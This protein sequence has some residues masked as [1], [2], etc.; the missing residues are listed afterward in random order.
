MEAPRLTHLVMRRP[1]LFQ[2][3]NITSLPEG[4]VLR[5]FN[6]E[7]DLKSLA[8]TLSAAFGFLWDAERVRS[9]L[10]EAPDVKAVYLVTW[11]GRPVATASSRY[12]PDLFPKAGYVHWV[13]T[14]P[15]HAR[16][17]LASALVAQLL[18]D[19]LDRGYKEAVLETDDFRIP[20]IVTYLKFGFLPIYD[21]N[22]EDHRAR[23]SVVFQTMFDHQSKLLPSQVV[24]GLF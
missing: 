22:E 24:D 3:P 11:Q 21:V 16:K 23:W 10:T 18:R 7:D 12:V 2:L 9:K 6:G 17:G 13:G 14:H 5:T 8:L 20:A 19:F 4:Y 15:D 1:H